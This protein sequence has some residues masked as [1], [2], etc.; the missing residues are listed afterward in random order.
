MDGAEGD[1]STVSICER[2]TLDS[3]S[4]FEGVSYNINICPGSTSKMDR[5]FTI[6]KRFYRGE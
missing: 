2:W 6:L 1:G 3:R 5:I 4:T